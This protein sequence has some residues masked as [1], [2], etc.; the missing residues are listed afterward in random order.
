MAEAG[1]RPAHR[2][3]PELRRP[4]AEQ[5]AT[6]PRRGRDHDHHERGASVHAATPRAALIAMREAR[7]RLRQRAFGRLR[8]C[9]RHLEDPGG[10]TA[11]IK[12]MYVEGIHAR[13][14]L[15]RRVLRWLEDA[16]FAAGY[17]SG[18]EGGRVRSPSSD[19]IGCSTRGRF[20]AST[21]SNSTGLRWRGSRL[22]AACPAVPRP[23]M[24]PR[25]ASRKSS[26]ARS[27]T[28]GV[29]LPGR[30]GRWL[31]CRGAGAESSGDWTACW[32]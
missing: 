15:A 8:G 2:P 24:R 22:I 26:A 23:G 14:G 17:R 20:A 31:P 5:G 16:A 19:R 1:D 21:T 12:R 9:R 11:E 28:R 27:V 4:P 32:G 18:D 30:R 29:R 25:T 10:I 13:R 6:P 3:D 7:I